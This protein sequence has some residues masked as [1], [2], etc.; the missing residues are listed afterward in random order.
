MLISNKYKQK[1]Y[2]LGKFKYSNVSIRSIHAVE[3]RKVGNVSKGIFI[4]AACGLVAGTAL[5]L[6]AHSILLDPNAGN[7]GRYLLV[8]IGST[9]LVGIGII[10]GGKVGQSKITIPVY[11]SQKQYYENRDQLEK[12]SLKYNGGQ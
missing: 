12:Y 2:D 6:I 9:A 3:I 1:D 10:I 11:G 8:E 7:V 5:T 4:S